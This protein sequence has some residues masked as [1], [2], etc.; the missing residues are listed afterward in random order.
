[1]GSYRGNEAKV[2]SSVVVCIRSED[3]HAASTRQDLPTID[4]RLELIEA[5]GSLTMAYLKLDDVRAVRHVSTI[6]DAVEAAESEEGIAAARPNLLA[7][8]PPRVA[9]RIGDVMP[10]GVDVAQL[11]FFDEE[12][13]ASLR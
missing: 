1:M 5:L 11:H 7:A 8:F 2:G 13:G 4:A 3:L 9:L 6:E 10:V 12:T